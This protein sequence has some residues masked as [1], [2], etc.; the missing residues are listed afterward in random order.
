MN[1]RVIT[2]GGTCACLEETRSVFEI[3][4]ENL[5]RNDSLE[6]ILQWILDRCASL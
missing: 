1:V 4:L 2:L 6:D 5:Q 3:E